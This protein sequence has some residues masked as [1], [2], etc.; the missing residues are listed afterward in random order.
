MELI[1]REEYCKNYCKCAGLENGCEKD[2][3][4]L[5]SIPTIEEIVHGEWI[6]I[7]DRMPEEHDSIFANLY[8]TD[9]WNDAMFRKT[10][11]DVNVVWEYDNGTRVVKIMCTEDGEFREPSYKMQKVNRHIGCH[12][13]SHQN[14]KLLTPT[15]MQIN[16]GWKVQL[17]RGGKSL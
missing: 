4:R 17:K 16:V 5:W 14:E 15:D 3:C 1:D 11:D 8:G 2:K 9:E 6:N 12:Y 7:E 13:Q 10:S